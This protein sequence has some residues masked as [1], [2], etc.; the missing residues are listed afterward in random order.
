MFSPINNL[1]SIFPGMCDV[2]F[3][4]TEQGSGMNK[5]AVQ[6]Y[7]LVAEYSFFSSL[8]QLFLS[9]KSLSCQN[10]LLKIMRNLKCPLN[11]LSEQR[12]SN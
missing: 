8:L 3:G 12:A 11:T 1:E 9:P 10:L 6:K 4:N 2:Y 7:N 5:K